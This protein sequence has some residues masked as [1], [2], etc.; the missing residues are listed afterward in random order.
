MKK[1]FLFLTCLCALALS[2]CGKAKEDSKTCSVNVY[3]IDG[4]KLFSKDISFKEGDNLLTL[5]KDN[6]TV[7][8]ETSQYGEYIFS[9]ANSVVDPNYY[10]AIYENDLYSQTSIDGIEINDKDKFDFKVECYNPNFTE[11]D[12]IIDQA[13]YKYAKT[14]FKENIAIDSFKNS[15]GKTTSNYWDFMLSRLMVKNGYDTFKIEGIY[16][17]SFK[18]SLKNYDVETLTGT[19]LG[20]YYYISTAMG[21]NVSDAYKNH[22]NAYVKETLNTG[23]GFYGEYSRPFDLS[24]ASILSDTETKTNIYELID[25][26]SCDTEY[27]YD[28]YCWYLASKALFGDVDDDFVISLQPNAISEALLLLPF[29]ATNNPNFKS[30]LTDLISNYYDKTNNVFFYNNET[31]AN[32]LDFFGANQVYAALATIKVFRDMGVSANLFA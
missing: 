21:I 15:E 26:Y 13:L 31:K 24:I 8:T 5:L 10:L 30:V 23:Y 20:V 9:I 16:K 22:Y 6:T 12:Y 17:D 28:G 1:G 4:E 14:K 7:K 25:S 19:D 2:S 32:G 27:G 11:A 18:T 3:D 29:A